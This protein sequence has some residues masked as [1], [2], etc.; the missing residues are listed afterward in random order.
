LAVDDI[1]RA[2]GFVADIN[3]PA[4]GGEVDAVGGL[5]AG[6]LLHHL[7]GRRVDDMNAVPGAVGDVDPRGLRCS[8][9]RGAGGEQ[10]EI[11][12]RGCDHGALPYGTTRLRPTMPA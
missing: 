12:E 5:D 6:D 10:G 3:A 4:V 9:Q 7:A 8:R 1:E 2:V 11:A